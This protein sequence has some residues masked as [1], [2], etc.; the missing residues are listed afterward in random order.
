MEAR[1]RA[2]IENR[3][4]KGIVDLFREVNGDSNTEQYAFN[5]EMLDTY[6]NDIH[7]AELVNPGAVPGAG[8]AAAVTT[9]YKLQSDNF[10]E[11]SG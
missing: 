1:V 4:I 6:F 10:K 11:H 2:E 3:N 9:L 5:Q 8:A 7:E